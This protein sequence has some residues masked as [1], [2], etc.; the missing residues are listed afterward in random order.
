[1]SNICHFVS[2]PYNI[3][4]SRT[5]LLG[6]ANPLSL[7]VS[8]LLQLYLN[9]HDFIWHFFLLEIFYFFVDILY[10]LYYNNIC[11]DDGS[12]IILHRGVAQLG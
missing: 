9:N 8:D 1:M 4:S 2:V 6:V 10:V 12:Q 5:T 11:V 3:S 7:F